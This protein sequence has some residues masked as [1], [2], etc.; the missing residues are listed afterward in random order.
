MFVHLSLY[1][2][3][4]I[5]R[6]GDISPQL[7]LV[8]N[9]RCEHVDMRDG[10]A[11]AWSGK[12]WSACLVHTLWFLLYRWPAEGQAVAGQGSVVNERVIRCFVSAAPCM[13]DTAVGRRLVTGIAQQ[14]FRPRG[15]G[16]FAYRTHHSFTATCP[17]RGTGCGVVMG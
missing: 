16:R 6:H 12:Q 7:L 11:D 5:R 10:G 3:D 9:M 15:Q 8:G 14:H 2:G 1:G 4:H 13:Y 17:T